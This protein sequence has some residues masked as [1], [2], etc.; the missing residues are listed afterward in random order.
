MRVRAGVNGLLGTDST[1]IPSDA[2]PKE[3]KRS[4]FLNG[5][6]S[7]P[8]G[9]ARMLHVGKAAEA[10]D[11]HRCE[12]NIES[13]SAGSM[14]SIVSCPQLQGITDLVRMT[15]IWSVCLTIFVRKNSPYALDPD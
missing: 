7:K 5:H 10:N 9:W 12:G 4:G 3:K 14:R 1:Y 6:P 13:I 2:V 8:E 11:Q 15:C